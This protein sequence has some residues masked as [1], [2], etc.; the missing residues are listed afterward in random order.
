MGNEVYTEKINLGQNATTGI[1]QHKTALLKIYPN[2]VH[3]ELRIS[4]AN[5]Y[6]GILTID[7]YDA[8]GRIQT[9]E[10]MN[11]AG[12][13]EIRLN[14]SQLPA[15]FYILSVSSNGNRMGIARFM[16]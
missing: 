8:L 11:V 3:E 14:T 10:S 13:S 15:G 16:K 6:K 5:E 12:S 1:K 9:M 7:V 2:P 4:L